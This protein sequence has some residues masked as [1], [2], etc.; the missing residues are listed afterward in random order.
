MGWTALHCAARHSHTDI[1]RTLLL[2]SKI[3][4]NITTND[5]YTAYHVAKQYGNTDTIDLLYYGIQL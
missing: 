1:V 2:E 3:N 5:G 4:D